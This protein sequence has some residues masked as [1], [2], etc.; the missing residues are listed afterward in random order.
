MNDSATKTILVA[1]DDPSIRFVL[2]HALVRSGFHVCCFESGDKLLDHMHGAG[3]DL[4]ITDI[5]MP[6]GSGLDLLKTLKT[7]HPSMPVIVITAQSTLRNAVHALERGAF[8]Y[9]PKPFDINTLID[10]VNRA[11]IHSRPLSE[12]RDNADLDRF[13]GIIGSSMA[14][15][16]LFRVIGRLAN[17]EMTVLIHGESGTGKELVARAIH[18]CSPRRN[19]PF[20]AINMA[21]IPRSLIESELFG[22]EKGAFTGAIS[23]RPGHFEQARGGSL[24]LDEIGDMPMEA[25]TRLLR[26]LQDGTYTQVGGTQTIHSDVRI[27]AASHQDLPA[28]I[29]AGRFREDLFY[30]LNVIPIHVPSLRSR[31]E[32]IPLL[33][34]YFL[35]RAAK[36]LGLSR[37]RLAPTTLDCLAVHSWPGNVRE[38]ENL[39]HRLMV[40][41]PDEVI[42]PGHLDLPEPRRPDLPVFG[43]ESPSPA[44]FA[45]VSAPAA[46]FP[47]PVVPPV[48]AV[49]NLP[50]QQAIHNELDRFFAALNGLPPTNLYDFILRLVEEPLLDRVLRETRG[51]QVKAAQVLGINRNTLR[52]KIQELGIVPKR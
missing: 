8:E 1:D 50:L 6:S 52:K 33:A 20:T 17:S 43:S 12:H 14:M 5:V 2:E 22:H 38:L 19:Q 45:P 39:I 41:V 28:A 13:G 24:F 34:D 49:P 31:R 7:R 27:I 15:Q 47:P 4:V 42:Q 37:K 9:L 48:A 46:P 3:A 16:E 29:A 18:A 32:D 23:R 51:N 36:E 10:L 25:Q 11:L 30:R 26:V 21:A 44:M 35:D 40:L